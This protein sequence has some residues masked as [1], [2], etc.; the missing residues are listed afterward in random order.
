MAVNGLEHD[1]LLSRL[2]KGLPLANA[3]KQ[4]NLKGLA[5]PRLRWWHA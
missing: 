1:A 4:G 3:A 2:E 5:R